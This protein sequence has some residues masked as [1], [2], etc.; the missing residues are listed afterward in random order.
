MAPIFMENSGES[1]SNPGCTVPTHLTQ[2]HHVSGWRHGGLAN[3][4]N[5]VLLCNAAHSAS[6]PPAGRST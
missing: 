4:D 5:A 1:R 2:V 6:I 3:I